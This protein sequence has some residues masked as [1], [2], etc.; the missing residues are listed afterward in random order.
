MT[1][2]RSLRFRLI[3]VLILVTLVPVATVSVLMLRA[4]A[5]AFRAYSD[6][7]SISDAQNIAGQVGVET[8]SQVFVV[9][10]QGETEAVLAEHPA[11]PGTSYFGVAGDAAGGGTAFGTAGGGRVSSGGGPGSASGSSA[12]VETV[13]MANASGSVSA[14]GGSGVTA[15]STADIPDD[16][17][18]VNIP[19]ISD[20][21]FLDDVSRSLLIAIG[22]AVAGTV[23]MAFLIARHVVR[24][25]EQL[26]DAA[27][28]MAAGDLGR[29]VTVRSR[30]EIGV[31]AEAFNTMADNRA[32]LE[33]LRRNMVNDVAHELRAPLG[34]LQGY[35][36]VLRDGLTAPTP[37]V[38]AALHEESLSLNRLVADL[39][40]LALAEAGQLPLVQEPVVLADVVVSAVEAFASKATAQDL[41]LEFRV[42]ESLPLVLADRA[43]LAQVFRNLLANACAHTPPGGRIS[44]DA[45]LFGNEIAV[46]VRDTGHGIAPEHLPYVFERFY[47]ADAARSRATG[48]AGLGLAI[49]K[50]LVEAQGGTV[51]ASSQPGDGAT[52]TFTLPRADHAVAIPA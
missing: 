24:P 33:A 11:Q 42:P 21:A 48:G 26:T 49:V 27:H 16:A 25:V 41:G 44:V 50:H 14:A 34:N 40:E 29:R 23:L 2:L 28:G 6:E 36:E 51:S 13:G 22:A 15:F 3:L 18:V 35:L 17:L 37:D 39:Q 38:L 1:M 5:E 9:G 8:G 30:D 20:K 45:S 12:P 46:S 10:G 31:L 32:H 7:R 52:L 19:S 4:T 43:R 47:R